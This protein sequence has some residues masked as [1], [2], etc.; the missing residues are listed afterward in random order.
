MKINGI[1]VIY[2]PGLPES[3]SGMTNF[4]ERG[5]INE[6]TVK[7]VLHEMYRLGTSVIGPAG[8][9]GADGGVAAETAG[10]HGFADKAYKALIG[11]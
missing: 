1:T 11:N 4:G 7:T 3:L 5:F 2:E 8:S 6:E 9:A 10:A